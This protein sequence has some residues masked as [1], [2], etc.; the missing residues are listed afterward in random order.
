M[1]DYWAGFFTLPA[2]ALTG[3][4]LL[5][6]YVRLIEHLENHGYTVEGKWRR[7]PDRISDFTLKHDIWTERTRGP[8]F[9]GHWYRE[10]GPHNEERHVNRWIAIGR[11]AGPCLMFFK[12]RTLTKETH[13]V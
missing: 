6:A 11:P 12:K 4:V 9:Y 13:D 1:S 3:F 8:V 7:S 10:R 5:V 2:V